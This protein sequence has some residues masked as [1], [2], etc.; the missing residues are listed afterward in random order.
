MKFQEY[1]LIEKVIKAYHG[2]NKEFDKFNM[3]SFFTTD[4]ENVNFY[5]KDRRA[6]GTPRVVEVELLINKPLDISTK[7]GAFKLFDIAKQNGVDIQVD[8]TE[9]GWNFQSDDIEK[10]GGS[11]PTNPLDLVYV[12]KV[13]ESLK[14]NGYDAVFD[15]DQ[16]ERF[17]IETYVPLD[18][19]QIRIIK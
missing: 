13:V 18:L 17:T 11:E 6:G 2:T 9:H 10:F 15:K 3:P 4:K 7:D 14:K 19:K 5:S 16:L 1:Y 8:E 12:P